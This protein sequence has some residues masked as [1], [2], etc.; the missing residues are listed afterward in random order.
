MNCPNCNEPRMRTTETFS[1]PALTI[2]TK[3]CRACAWTYTSREEVCDDLVIPDSVRR[4]KR[5][6]AANNLGESN[7]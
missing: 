7:E 2:R 1:L 6:P 3:K 5:G 4:A